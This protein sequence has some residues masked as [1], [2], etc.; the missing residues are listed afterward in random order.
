M[1]SIFSC[2]K[3]CIV[4]LVLTQCT[5]G[6]DDGPVEIPGNFIQSCYQL[7]GHD[8]FCAAMVNSGFVSRTD[9]RTLGAFK[10]FAVDDAT[11]NA[12]FVANQLTEASF[13]SDSQKQNL[14]INAH[15]TS[16]NLTEASLK[17]LSGRTV[18]ISGT[19]ENLTINGLKATLSPSSSFDKNFFKLQGILPV[20]LP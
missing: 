1:K 7:A 8:I 6:H 9:Y 16:G 2:F 14:F 4:L 20:T 11:M 5:T 12:F 19:P 15:I 13:K 17:L 3:L 18:N 10:V